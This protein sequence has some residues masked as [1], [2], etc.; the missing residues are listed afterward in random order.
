MAVSTST[1]IATTFLLVLIFAHPAAAFGAGNIASLSRIEGQN[2]RHGD[3]EDALLSVVMAR[4]AGGKKFSK[5]D[6]QR[7]YFGNWLRD[8]SQA[9]DVG[10]V[11][12]VSAEAIR[13]LLWVLGFLSFGYG[14]GEFE[15]TTERLG[16]Y[17]PT[18]HID[19]PL[20][21]AEGDDARRY[22][23]RLRGPI[24]EERELAIDT[25]TGLKHYIATEDIGIATSAGLLRSVFGR[26]IELGR[27]YGRSRDKTELYEALRLLGTGLHCLEDYAAH[28]N[29]TELCLIEMG[30]QDV[31]PHVGR[32]TMME[33][34]GVGYPVYPII[35]GTFGGVDFLHS[36]MGEFSDKATQSELQ[37]L[38][39][40][41][42]QSQGEGGNKSFIKDLLDKIPS[43]IFGGQ[44]NSGKMDEFQANAQHQQQ[45]P[46]H[47]SPKEPEEWTEYLDNVKTQVYPVLEWHDN[48]MKS[49]SEAIE[50][51]P[52]LPDLIEQVQNEINV[53]VFSVIAP[54]VIPI[55]NQVKTE[56]ETGSSE[57]IQSSRDQQHNIFNNDDCTDPTHSMLSKDHFSNVLNEP[58]GKVAQEVVKWAVPQIM[59]AW[60]DEYIDVDRTLTRIIHGVFHHPAHRNHG[61]DGQSDIRMLMFG[62]V[63]QWWNE[64]GRRG[65]DSLRRQLSREGVRN[66]DNH[67]PGVRDTGHGCGKPLSLPKHKSKNTGVLGGLSGAG[68]TRDTDELAHMAKKAVGGGIL[69]DLVG[70]IVTGAGAEI[71]AGGS[72]YEGGSRVADEY[73]K[74]KKERKYSYDEEDEYKKKKKE[75]KQYGDYYDEDRDESKKKKKEQKYGDYYDEDVYKKKKEK[76]GDDNEDEYKKKK[77]EKKYKGYDEDEDEGE[78]YKYRSNDDDDDEYKKKK[79]K[80]KKY[81]HEKKGSG[82]ESSSRYG[83]SD[84]EQPSY[85][86][87]QEHYGRS[88]YEQTGYGGGSYG[89]QQEYSQPSYGGYQQSGDYGERQYGSEYGQQRTYDSGYGQTGGYGQQ[90]QSYSGGDSYSQGYGGG[91]SRHSSGYGRQEYGESGSYGGRRQSRSRERESRQYSSGHYGGRDERRHGS[92]ERQYGGGYGHS[93]KKRYDNDGDSGDEYDRH[94]HHHHHRRRRGS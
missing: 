41:M 38:E 31:F 51:I 17:Q 55:I 88:E 94:G 54:Y 35:T 6:L 13:I 3:I 56:L 67:K 43:E 78:K 30:E 14:T 91:E 80:E 74:E 53:F 39:G 76:Y 87:R 49:I 16:T 12:Y 45:S 7:V 92:E 4:V 77:K 52:V 5:L 11:K 21:Y 70:G 18:E 81:K 29:F 69:G 2:W 28:S 71:L 20:G 82:D 23:R 15:V 62:A 36:V 48:L 50:K 93:Y 19:N 86:S 85:G 79:K 57:V 58:A 27:S 59:D 37:S 8:Y 65:Q 40:V 34:P 26:C 90:T 60:D 46:P 83:R 44:D 32:R 22:D 75:K 61:Q 64:Q 89:R 73:K 66:G 10:T 47:V 72:G 24:D 9:V 68:R 63:E 84:Y 42:E 1:L 25:R 33:L